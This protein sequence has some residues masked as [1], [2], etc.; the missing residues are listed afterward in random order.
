MPYRK[1]SYLLNLLIGLLIAGLVALVAFA[2]VSLI[3]TRSNQDQRMPTGD[4]AATDDQAAPTMN[5]FEDG[6][7]PFTEAIKTQLEA[8][9]GF[10][11]LIS[12]TDSGFE[13]AAFEIKQGETVRFTNNS[14]REL[15]LTQTDEQGNA[16]SAFT[17]ENTASN[18]HLI[19]PG[20]FWETSF[21]NTGRKSFANG[22]ERGGAGLLVITVN[23]K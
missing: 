8:S 22:T 18:C 15:R 10:Q 14:Q 16:T 19:G 2:V 3:T 23:D 5:E 12:Y 4:P 9:T 13:P 20:Q 11:Y 7:P 17:C 6:R 1:H 21:T